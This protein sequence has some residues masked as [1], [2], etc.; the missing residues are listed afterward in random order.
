MKGIS[1]KLDFDSQLDRAKPTID[2][3]A[4]HRFDRDCSM[5]K[6]LSQGSI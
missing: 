5:T 3:S 1:I 6:V 2:L 4:F